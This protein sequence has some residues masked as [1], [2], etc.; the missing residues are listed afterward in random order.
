[1]SGSTVPLFRNSLSTSFASDSNLGLYW[2]T[3]S[4]TES[5]LEVS[6]FR[7][8]GNFRT[9]F[10]S[11]FIILSVVRLSARYEYDIFSSDRKENLLSL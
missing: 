8:E 7:R 1:M 3:K 6:C 4:L 5:L 9:K 11:T 10:L 2:V